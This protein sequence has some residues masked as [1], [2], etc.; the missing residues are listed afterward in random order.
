M[1]FQVLESIKKEHPRLSQALDQ[2][3]GYI[4]RLREKGQTEIEPSL[5]A[6]SLGVTEANVTALLMLLEDG[7]MVRHVYNIFCGKNRSFLTSVREVSEIPRVVYCKFCDE[8]HRS[9]GAR[10]GVGDD[11]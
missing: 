4:L 1:Q 7:Q 9:P 2:L 8:E 6:Q 5:A 11:A 10:R 3:V